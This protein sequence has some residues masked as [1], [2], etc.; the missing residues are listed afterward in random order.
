MKNVT[1]NERDA[2]KILSI[3]NCYK[4]L[5]KEQLIQCIPGSKPYLFFHQELTE[6]QTLLNKMLP[7]G[8]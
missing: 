6:A 7:E 8:V 2:M 5:V 1:F 3:I 4:E